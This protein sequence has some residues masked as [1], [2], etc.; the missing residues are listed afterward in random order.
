MLTKVRVVI[1]G[2]MEC[3]DTINKLWLCLDTHKCMYYSHE[4]TNDIIFLKY[5]TTLEEAFIFGFLYS[6]AI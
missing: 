3:G 1:L 4:I 5:K 6:G 2:R